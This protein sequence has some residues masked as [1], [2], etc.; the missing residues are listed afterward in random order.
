MTAKPPSMIL[1][2]CNESQVPHIV[3][4]HISIATNDNSSHQRTDIEAYTEAASEWDV[5]KGHGHNVP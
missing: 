5:H 3:N 4:H 2:H 1:D